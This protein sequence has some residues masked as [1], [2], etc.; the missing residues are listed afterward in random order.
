MPVRIGPAM[1][2]ALYIGRSLDE[3]NL[4]ERD[5]Q[6]VAT[7]A[8]QIAVATQNQR[9]FAEAESQ[10]QRLQSIVDTM[11][12]GILVMDPEGNVLLSNETLLGLLGPELRPSFSGDPQPYPVVRTTTREP[13]PR[14]EWP[15]SRVFSSGESVLADDMLI[16]HPDGEIS[17]LAQAAPIFGPDGSIIA[18]VGAFQ[19][20]TELQLL[21]HALQESLR[22]T[23]LLYEASRAIARAAGMEDLLQI[24][25]FQINL[26]APDRSYIFLRELGTEDVQAVT[27]T[28]SQPTEDL[29]R[30]EIVA[31]SAMFKFEPTI[32]QLDEAPARIAEYLRDR[33]LTTLVCFP[34]NVR[35][36]PNGWIVIG[37][38]HLQSITT[39]LRRFMTTLADQAGISIENQRL[40]AHTEEALQETSLL[41]HATRMLADAQNPA[42]ILNAFSEH[43][44]SQ[45]VCSAALYA[46]LSETTSTSYAAIEVLATWG[47]S[48][49][50][51]PSGTRYRAKQFPFWDEATGSVIVHISDVTQRD[52]LNE[53]VQEELAA[54]GACAI[55][56]IPLRVAD[57]PI[58]AIVIG[59]SQPGTPDELQSRIFNALADQA[60]IALENT[61]LY[62]QAQRRARQ[63]STSAEIGRAV[64]SILYLDELLPQIVNLIR[65][66]FEYDHVQI[67]LLSEDGA[68]ANLVA[69]TSEAGRKL[70]EQHHSLPVGGQSVIGQ[71]TASGQPQIAFDT[72]DARVTYRPNPLLPSTRSEIALPLITRGEIVGALDVQSNQPRAFTDEDVQMLASLAD[73]AATAIDNAKLFEL[74]EQR[75][76]EMT[77]LFNVTTA[78]AA[79]P[80][81]D[82]SLKQA[83]DTLCETMHVASASVYL[84]DESGQYM[85]KGAEVGTTSPE[86]HLTR[87]SIDRG[88]IGWVTRH[89]EAVIIDDISQ[90]PR[91][92]PS[93]VSTGAIMAVPLQTAGALVGVLTVESHRVRAFGDDDLRLLRTLSG[94][95]AAI[96]QNSRLLNEVQRANER[97]LEVDKLKTN[98]LAAMSH[99]LRTPLNSIIG[100]SRVILKGI[101]GPLTDMQEQ[102]LST[103]YESGKHLLGLVNDILDQ[104]KLEAG[105]TELTLGY[106]K[107]PELITGVM[108]S[109]VGLTRDKPIRLHTEIAEHL[110]DTYGDE[111]R[112]RQVLLNL[113]SNAS[114]F[115]NEG[116]ITVAAF[117]IIEDDRQYVQ[118]SVTDTGIG[119]AEKDMPL[120]FEA[121]QQ[122]DNSLT[123]AV[124]GT[125]MGL[126]LAKSLVELQHGRIWVESEPGVGSTFSI[127]IPTAPP[128]DEETGEPDEVLQHTETAP[129][130]MPQA[131][132]PRKTILVVEE[133]L[134]TVS[135]YR[136]YLSKEGYEVL[137]VN[138]PETVIG[139]VNTHA[140]HLILLDVNI[141]DQAGWEILAYLKQFE[142]T[143]DIP[144]IICTLNPDRQRGLDMG[145]A[146]YLVK[147]FD[148]EQL[149]DTLRYAEA[150]MVRQRILIVDDKPETIRPFREALEADRRYEVLEVTSGQE[151]LD[152]LRLT[153]TIDLVI[154]DL[155]MPGIDGFEVLQA[156]RS[157]EQTANVPVL[158]LTAEDINAEE[159]AQLDQIDVYRKDTIDEA[160]LVDRI[161]TR[162]GTT[163]ENG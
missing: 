5:I 7:L 18:V 69:A 28:A 67:F 52:R 12:T 57:R 43:A 157:S 128:L 145:A 26:L 131:T 95:L 17:V 104:A 93:T 48:P 142:A 117:P 87:L 46:L 75:A 120:L 68:D 90:D 36:Y 152:I 40:F 127:T 133:D 114:K 88:V 160:G 56:V 24:T 38:T 126:P 35:G 76:E 101:D 102:D 73:M 122:I 89:N 124:G 65:D 130:K 140:P 23:T 149:L 33:G 14:G 30:Q 42:E 31:L 139:M 22:E 61:R 59:Y 32:A 8:S 105:K 121:F 29:S 55:T 58:G 119:I 60:A 6:L 53:M 72:A 156:L 4:D 81:L 100:F 91:R 150:D 1:V 153:G 37:F 94:S 146:A 77:F 9:L 19:D 112:T 99:E 134:Q 66:S 132:P 109:A 148:N 136:R 107:L 113:I 98:F 16:Q 13:Y 27:L 97:L 106:F 92:L 84:P 41:Y 63:L 44:I 111:F 110:P 116:S 10:R 159:R 137:G 123:R 162:L 96:I 21:E 74:A 51:S 39:E 143:R 20:I 129:R 155:R 83:V 50:A 161:D 151:A 86:S 135:L 141:H 125:G 82:V 163:R 11:P 47:D 54:L 15:L 71:V 147:P 45:P 3:Q 2:G 25:L 85:L 158:V 49:A 103:I 78:A 79:S 64:T 34:L 108:S 118:V 62:Q 144:V 138:D 80:D 70:L 154:L 115:T